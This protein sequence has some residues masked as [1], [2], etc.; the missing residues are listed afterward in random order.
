MWRRRT[1]ERKVPER[2]QGERMDQLHRL[3][4]PGSDEDQEETIQRESRPHGTHIS[5]VFCTENDIN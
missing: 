5:V 3:L 1:L 2:R 4:F